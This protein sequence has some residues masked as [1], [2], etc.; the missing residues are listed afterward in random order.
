MA[1]GKKRALGVS[2]YPRKDRGVFYLS[3]HDPLQPHRYRIQEATPFRIDDPEGWRKANALA[4]EKA[5]KIREFGETSQSEQWEAWV[6]PYLDH[7]YAGSPLTL[8]RYKGAWKWL[9]LFLIREVKVRVP[10]ALTYAHVRAYHQWRTSFVKGSGRKVSGNTALDDLKVLKI[11]MNEAVNR[12]YAPVNPA[13]RVKIPKEKVRHARELAPAE[14]A[15]IE[16]RL[17]AFVAEDEKERAWMPI[18]YK[19]ARY[20]GCRLRETRVN[21]RAGAVNLRTGTITFL[22]KGRKKGDGD[23]TMLHPKLHAMFADLI[24]RG[25]IWSLDYGARP[26]LLWRKFFDSVGLTDA[27]FHCLRSTVITE[28]ARAGVPIS[29]AM[30]YVLHASEE[31]HRSYQRLTAGDL[32]AASSAIGGA[33]AAVPSSGMHVQII[34]E[35]VRGGMTT[36]EAMRRVLH[37]PTSLPLPSVVAAVG[38]DTPTRS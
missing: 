2:V 6:V 11:V 7:Q 37:G 20:Q 38:A 3:F 36:E 23:T 32:S 13:L 16:A 35:L 21:L 25:E 24:A 8:K 28:M 4:Q 17:P 30:R 22:T 33:P 1:A 19:I 27:W 12:G 10:R 14:L 29:Q 9:S 15:L 18:A 5:A 34:A 26:S 31:I